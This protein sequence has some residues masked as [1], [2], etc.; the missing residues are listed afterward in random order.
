MLKV[1]I[2]DDEVFTRE[3]ILEQLPWKKLGVTQIEQA[4]DGV[5]ALEVCKNFS[6]D[7]IL[8]DVRMP[9][10]DGID[11]AFKLRE[12]YPTCEIIFMSGYSDKEYLKSAI[13]LKAV[14]YVE[15]PIDLDELEAAF[16]NAIEE[17]QRDITLSESI[18]NR[19]ALE[20]ININFDVNAFKGML[21]AQ[22]FEELLNAH[23]ITLLINLT[24]NKIINEDMLL[25][26]NNIISERK[27][28]S[29][30]CYKDSNLIIVHIYSD[31]NRM[32]LLKNGPIEELCT[33]ISH[34]IGENSKFFISV[35]SVVNGIEKIH[36]SYS[37]ALGAMD[38]AFFYDYNSII[39]SQKLSSETYNFDE[40]NY[41]LFEEYLLE[42]D[43][44]QITI[45][46][47][48]LTRDIRSFTGTPSN[49]VKDMYYKL[50]LILLN[51][52]ADRNLKIDDLGAKGP[53]ESFSEF[54]T[55]NEMEGYFIEKI[56][57]AFNSLAQKD[58]NSN[59]ITNIVNY[60]CDNYDDIDLSITKISNNIYLSP[61]YISTIFKEE[62]GKTINRY[63][64]EYRLTKAK[65]LLKSPDIKI[66][67][68]ALKVGYSDGNYFTK[69]FKKET[70]LTPSEYRKK[71]LS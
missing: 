13:K 15:K 51:F 59:P 58:I 52:I 10:M 45:L 37:S 30:S 19:I 1:L 69:I 64:S 5:N 43:K 68:V 12:L 7:I 34:F 20:A 24:D 46:I 18:R 41:K 14:S 33:D 42:G 9:R 36:E 67:D 63:I 54:Y 38:K 49:Y 53:F 3:G 44:H 60:I 47:R 22:S 29:I 57:A 66:N 11:L 70:G 50:F 71:F 35:G 16:I 23:F 40:N 62:T 28:N 17:K 56:E 21:S 4:F 65:D 27:L 55:I 25:Q 2:A 61:A 39:Y 26:I 31:N 32:H 8:T 48:R 6:P